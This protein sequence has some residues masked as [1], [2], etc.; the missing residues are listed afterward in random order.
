MKKKAP[1]AT[2]VCMKIRNKPAIELKVQEVDF[3]GKK[4]SEKWTFSFKNPKMAEDWI[5]EVEEAKKFLEEK[6][7]ISQTVGPG[8]FNNPNNDPMS[9][10]VV[11]QPPIYPN[12]FLT[13]SVQSP[14]RS[15][16]PIDQPDALGS[17]LMVTAFDMPTT[18]VYQQPSSIVNESRISGTG[19]NIGS[20]N[21]RMTGSVVQPENLN[22]SAISYNNNYTVPLP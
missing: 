15:V 10:T 2:M 16:L 12:E 17:H 5:R 13:N 4:T 9:M 11:K 14:K 21:L 8:G 20:S 22:K 18:S 3:K 1:I 7:P 6:P 19:P